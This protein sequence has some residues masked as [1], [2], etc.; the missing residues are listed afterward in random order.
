MF[1]MGSLV[2]WLRRSEGEPIQV[3]IQATRTDYCGNLDEG[4]DWTT[5]TLPQ[6][7]VD[8]R[9]HQVYVGKDGLKFLAGLL[10]FEEEDVLVPFQCRYS[11]M[12]TPA[13]YAYSIQSRI[14]Q[15][16]RQKKIDSIR[17]S[18]EDFR[19]AKVFCQEKEVE[20]DPDLYVI[21]LAGLAEKQQKLLENSKPTFG[22][23]RE[24][25]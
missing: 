21:K 18:P 1:G 20:Y 24:T 16:Q 14:V 10:L 4:E 17:V 25:N 22:E 7:E 9:L 8:I 5:I 19:V 11:V 3:S 2:E 6:R 15:I 23:A 12:V 13:W